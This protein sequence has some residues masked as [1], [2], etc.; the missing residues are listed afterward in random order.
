MKAIGISIRYLDPVLE[1]Q[2]HAN[3]N[4]LDSI[5]P[6]EHILKAQFGNIATPSG[7]SNTLTLWSAREKSK[8]RMKKW[9]AI[10][11]PPPH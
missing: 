3:G 7:F 10:S 11:A 2:T 6:Q 4:F 8:R 9:F 5:L 1:T